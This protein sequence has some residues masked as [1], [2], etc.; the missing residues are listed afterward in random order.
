MSDFHAHSTAIIE[1]NSSVGSGT[2]IWHHAHIRS[3]AIV[4]S[5]CVI[6]K[7]VYVDTEAVVGYGCKIQNNVN[8]Y[9]GVV[10]G[11]NVFVGPNVTFTND[12]RPR[13][14]GTNWSITP[15]IVKKGASIGAAA[16]IVCGITIGEYAMIGAGSVVTKNVPAHALV[17]GN[18]AK[19]VGWVDKEGKEIDR[20][21]EK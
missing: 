11:D 3:K 15:T 17:I 18:P 20:S 5:N 14:E 6:G 13:A 10:I 4:G 16:V 19:I 21:Y 1:E 9:K 7:N 8:I 12:K 2:N